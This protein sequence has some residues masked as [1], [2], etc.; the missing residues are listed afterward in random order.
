MPYVPPW[1][2]VQPSDFVQAAQAGAR[3]GTQLS[4]IATGAQSRREALRSS[5]RENAARIAAQQSMAAAHAA[6]T[7]R[8]NEAARRLREFEERNRIQL[9]QRALESQNERAAQALDATKAYHAGTLAARAEAND[10]AQQRADAYAAKGPAGSGITHMDPLDSHLLTDA[11][12][13]RR[14]AQSDLA[15]AAE[16]I[17][18]GGEVPKEVKDRLDAANE[19]IGAI[20]KK[21]MAQAQQPQL[22]EGQRVRNKQTGQ[23]GTVVNGQIVPDEEEK[24]SV[25]AGMTAYE[26]PYSALGLPVSRGFMYSGENA[27]VPAR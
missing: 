17:T 22:Q 23:T 2:N 13:R 4:E 21:Y 25:D 26:N 15:K 9:A 24:E 11:L 3:I 18:S 19:D 14:A 10:I 5:E 7:A 1:L 27:E 16:D 8:Q 6:E 12:M 20:S